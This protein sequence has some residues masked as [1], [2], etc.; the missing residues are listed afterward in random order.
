[1]AK[2]ERGH[3]TLERNEGMA[4]HKLQQEELWTR[5]QQWEWKKSCDIREAEKQRTPAAQVNFF[6]DALKNVIPKFSTD[7]YT[8]IF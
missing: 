3:G 1:M 2:R 7:A 8:N 5:Q 4:L 6:G